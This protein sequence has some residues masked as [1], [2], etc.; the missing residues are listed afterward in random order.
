MLND[1]VMG[2]FACRCSPGYGPPAAGQGLSR[3]IIGASAGKTNVKKEK[4]NQTQPPG[5]H[6]Q[7]KYPPAR[8]SVF[9]GGLKLAVGSLRAGTG[10]AALRKDVEGC[11]GCAFTAGSGRRRFR[12]PGA[13][14]KLGTGM[15]LEM[16]C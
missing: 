12:G 8:R 13:L 16:P 9:P 2:A 7:K 11:A 15:P 14:A 1:D 3:L 10:R 4:K 5:G 6:P